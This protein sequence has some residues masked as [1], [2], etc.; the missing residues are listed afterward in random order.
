MGEK[1]GKG[2]KRRENTAEINSWFGL[3]LYITEKQL[4]AFVLSISNRQ[5]ELWCDVLSVELLELNKVLA[6]LERGQVMANDSGQLAVSELVSQLM[7]LLTTINSNDE[8][9]RDPVNVQLYTDLI[10]NWLLNVYDQ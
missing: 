7:S 6:E 10:L 3:A 8:Q 9:T 4:S 5:S 1:E 2:R